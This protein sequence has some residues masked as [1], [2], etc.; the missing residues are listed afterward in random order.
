MDIFSWM[1]CFTTYESVLGPA[2]PK[3]APELMALKGF[4]YIVNEK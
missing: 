2:C 3:V 4:I 1:Q